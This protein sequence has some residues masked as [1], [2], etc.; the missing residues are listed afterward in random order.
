M[1]HFHL[2]RCAPDKAPFI[3]RPPV[4][5]RP[6][7]SWVWVRLTWRRENTD[8]GQEK[9]FAAPRSLATP[10]ERS[11][12]GSQDAAAKSWR[13]GCASHPF[14][15]HARHSVVLAQHG[16]ANLAFSFL[17]RRTSWGG[18]SGTPPSDEGVQE[19]EVRKLR[20]HEEPP[21]NLVETVCFRPKREPRRILLLEGDQSFQQK[22]YRK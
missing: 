10:H 14:R 22:D 12:L 1:V 19:V 7:N 8:R 5:P 16:D 15:N 3:P 2:P 4:V 9:A 11:A 17:L 21:G 18:R 6:R 13:M 20:D